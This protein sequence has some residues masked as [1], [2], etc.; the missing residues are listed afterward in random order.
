M[1][2]NKILKT[3]FLLLFLTLLGITIGCSSGDDNEIQTVE[4]TVNGTVLFDDGDDFIGDVDGDFTGNGG[5]AVKTFFW[6]NSLITAEYNAD[7]TASSNGL[8]KMEVKDANGNLVLNK[9][10]RGGVEPDSFSGVTTSGT[11]GTWSVT[12]TLSS[13]NGDGSFSLSEGD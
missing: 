5:S 1:S 7:I 8:F 11:P 4:L 6:E 9:S 10:L 13:F 3:G 12:I 2:K